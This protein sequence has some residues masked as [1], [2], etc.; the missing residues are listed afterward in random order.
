R[1]EAQIGTFGELWYG[2]IEV[3]REASSGE[4]AVEIGNSS[5][6][7]EERFAQRLQ[8]LSEFAQ[9]TQDFGGFIFGQLHELVVGFDGLERFEK[10]GLPRAACA[11]HN[12][13]H[14]AAVLGTYRDHEPIV[15]QSDIVLA[16]T[17]VAR[18][19]ELLQCLLNRVARLCDA[20]SN[21]A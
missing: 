20:R 17:R 11:M 6:G 10:N 7:S 2:C 13:G 9:N 8:P 21:P 3:T 19:Q 14:T 4:D 15:A 12:A 5:R 1:L 18:S 16:R